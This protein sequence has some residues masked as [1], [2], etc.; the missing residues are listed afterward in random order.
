MTQDPQVRR[1]A[2]SVLSGLFRSIGQRSSGQAPA[3]DQF[4]GLLGEIEEFVAMPADLARIF[5][6][7]AV[8]LTDATL[9]ALEEAGFVL[10][11]GLTPA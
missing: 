9:T 4:A 7:M 3:D 8:E 6:T 1:E 2:H 11:K 5:L 10:L